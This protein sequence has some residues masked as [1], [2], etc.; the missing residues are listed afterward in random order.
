MKFLVFAVVIGVLVSGS[1]ALDCYHCAPAKAGGACDVTKVTCPPGKDACSAARFL[2]KPY[3]HFQKCM[4]FSDCE[5]VKL[6]AYINI[7]CC[8]KDFCNTFD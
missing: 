1:R 5:M 4:P 6:N 7:K 3:G 2:R 8:Q